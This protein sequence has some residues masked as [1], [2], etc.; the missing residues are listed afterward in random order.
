MYIYL[1]RNGHTHKAHNGIVPSTR[2]RHTLSLACLGLSILHLT[3]L[4]PSALSLHDVVVG[5][6]VLPA[7]PQLDSTPAPHHPPLGPCKARAVGVSSVRGGHYKAR[8]TAG[9]FQ[10]D[11]VRG[12]G[13]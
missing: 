10:G 8:G 2:V 5:S 12:V 7:P 3:P 9:H 13:H 1:T 6:V 11:K 4:P